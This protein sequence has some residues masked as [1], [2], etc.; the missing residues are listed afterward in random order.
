MIEVSYSVD[1]THIKNSYMLKTRKIIREETIRIM[2]ERK[3][4]GYNVSR[5]IDSYV[6]EWIGHNRLYK[7]G[8][9][10]DRTR[11]ADLEENVNLFKNLVWLIL[12]GI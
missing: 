2:D 3:K 11:D 6:R 12:G 8:I 4:K 10:K 9:C 1:N 7:L 5:S